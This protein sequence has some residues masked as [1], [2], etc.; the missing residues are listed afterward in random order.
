M[1]EAGIATAELLDVVAGTHIA[2]RSLATHVGLAPAAR[3]ALGAAA[4]V[5]D[6]LAERVEL[7][8]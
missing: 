2:I 8:L 5:H 1:Q 7:R 4:A 3:A 6:P